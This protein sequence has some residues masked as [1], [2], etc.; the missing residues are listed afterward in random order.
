MI[1]LAFLNPLLLFAIPLAAVPIAIHL[2]N[3]RRFDTR[4]WAAME[5][6]LRAMKRNRRRLQM[7]QWI[8]LLLRTLAVILLVLLVARPRLTGGLL[9]TDATHHVVLL[10]DSAS[11]AHRG[12][13]DDAMD[14]ARSA[15]EQL[16]ARL[17]VERPG[18]LLTLA[19]TSD[20][21]KPP[22]AMVAVDAELPRRAREALANIRAGDGALD[23][24]RT[25]R[26]VSRAAEAA[27]D[28]APR[29]ESYLVTDLRRS[30]W[31]DGEGEPAPAF[32]RW[33][34]ALDPEAAHLTLVDVGAR[35][36]ENLA[37]TA[38]RVA[39]RV[40]VAGVPVRIAVDVKNRGRAPSDPVEMAIEI[41]GSRFLRPVPALGPGDATAIEFEQTFRTA[42]WHGVRAALPA[43]RY[44]PDDARS[45]ALEVRP[46]VRA[47]LVDGAPGEE[48]RDSETFLLGVALLS[49]ADGAQ[50]VDLRVLADHE[51]AG[52]P[53]EQL[54][55]ADLVWL[56]NVSRITPDVA[57]RLEAFVR[58]GGGLAIWLGEQVDIAAYD[59]VLWKDG[60]GL[61]PLPLVG[62]DGD[63]DDPRPV[64]VVDPDHPLF[65]KA[66]EQL[67]LMFAEFVGVARWITMREDVNAP[68]EVLL[69][70][71]D[72]DGPVL[73]VAKNLEDGGRVTVIGTTAD[74]RWTN[75]AAWP[76]FP[77]IAAEITATSARPQDLAR[78]DL[79]PDGSFEVAV[80][81]AVHRP[82]VELRPRGDDGDTRTFAAPPAGTETV[83]VEIPMAELEG[84]GLFEVVRRTHAGAS[85]TTLIA[86]NP[87]LEEG[88]LDPLAAADL[89]ASLP[90]EL[91]GR[92]T[93]RAGAG[94]AVT[95]DVDAGGAWRVLGMLMLIGLLTES[96]LAWRFGRR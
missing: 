14:R 82:D 44:A 49:G 11:M 9:G 12:G 67:R 29:T 91:R 23:L 36:A 76:P 26:A 19:R 48:P 70:I 24:E 74:D 31:T 47:L 85:E 52:L 33:L 92:M 34:A 39:D 60:R 45:L 13:A 87:L 62:V 27:H 71:G 51:L 35:D 6:L 80:D 72:A 46:A 58:S 7:E 30:D 15:A 53:D 95:R 8:V 18:D 16:I 1:A 55:E 32:V 4:R 25:F 88:L 94:A 22:L 42:G 17:A 20:P 28:V 84:L 61:L 77:I 38:V 43:D 2:L 64:H 73:M 63:L 68:V 81:P 65:A 69:R 90:E 79:R 41:D 10:D 89:T 54:A 40:C 93:V 75:W 3:R 96:V 66:P 86:R 37:V 59:E 56:C 78:H 83:R 50:P 21:A 5:F 57:A